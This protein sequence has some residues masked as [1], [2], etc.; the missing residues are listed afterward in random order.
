MGGTLRKELSYKPEDI[1]NK[2]HKRVS[3]SLGS[4][5]SPFQK[6]K[7]YWTQL[8][9]K[10]SSRFEKSWSEEEFFESSEQRDL[11]K[12]LEKCSEHINL[13][14][15]IKVLLYLGFHLNDEKQT[16]RDHGLCQLLFDTRENYSEKKYEDQILIKEERALPEGFQ[17]KLDRNL[18]IG[19]EFL[20]A[21]CKLVGCGP[22]VAVAQ[23]TL[24]K[25]YSLY[26]YIITFGYFYARCKKDSEKKWHIDRTVKSY[27]TLYLL[28]EQV[29][30]ESELSKIISK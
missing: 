14:R 19:N 12:L 23:E 25:N 8:Y 28:A 7:E 5:G 2:L 11:R 18:G 13:L 6:S 30:E 17:V 16:V 10:G 20:F 3:S 22:L 29:F 24:M 15:F 9:Y 26:Q 1:E 27:N 4:Y 21:Q